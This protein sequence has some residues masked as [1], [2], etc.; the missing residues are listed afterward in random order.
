MCNVRIL[1]GYNFVL[2]RS[3]NKDIFSVSNQIIIRQITWIQ[4]LKSV[5]CFRRYPK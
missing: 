1:R 3:C 2:N 5:I 4:S